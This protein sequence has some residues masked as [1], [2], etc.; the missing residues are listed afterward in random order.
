MLSRLSTQQIDDA[1]LAR[2]KTK[3]RGV[4]D[5]RSWTIMPGW[6]RC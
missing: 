1:T 3:V 2:V 5:P 6:R 4:A